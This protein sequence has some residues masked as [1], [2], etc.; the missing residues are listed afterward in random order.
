MEAPEFIKSLRG[1]GLGLSVVF[2]TGIL[3]PLPARDYEISAHAAL[4]SAIID[5]YNA[6]YPDAEIDDAY[7]FDLIRGAKEEDDGNRSLNHFY[8]PV[9][10]RGLSYG[11]KT[12]MRS[13]SWAVADDTNDFTWQKGLNAY[14]QGDSHRAFLILGH[15]LHLLEDVSVPEHVRN[16][17][18]MLDSPYESFT[19]TLVPVKD[20]TPPLV[21]SSLQDYFDAMALYTNT[22][23]YSA[24]TID[25]A[26]Y[27]GPKPDYVAQ[28]GKYLYGFKTDESGSKYHLVRYIRQQNYS[29][30]KKD[31]LSPFLD[32]SDKDILSDYW[33]LLSAK[34]IRYGA[35]MAHTFIAEGEKLKKEQTT[36]K[37]NSKNIYATLAS[38]VDI[39]AST[40]ESVDMANDGLTEA[41]SVSIDSNAIDTLVM[42]I[43]TSAPAVK[44]STT[45][46]GAPKAASAK[47]TAGAAAKKTTVKTAPPKACTYVKTVTPTHGPV[48]INEVAWMGGTASAS[49]EWM[50][51]KNISD[52]PAVISGWQLLSRRGNVSIVI[53]AGATIPAG[54][55]Y[56]LERTDDNSVPNIPADFIY[57]GSLANTDDGLRLVDGNCKPAD[58]VD[59][60]PSWPA[61]DA[62]ARRTME[63]THDFSWHDYTGSGQGSIF[64]TPRAEN[65]APP[66]IKPGSATGGSSSASPS[67]SVAVQP[68][69]AP[70]V[71]LAKQFAKGDVVINE[72]LFD[73]D[74]S[75]AGKEFVELYNATDQNIDLAGWSLQVKSGA[76]GTVK[77]NNFEDG[78]LIVPNGCFL[79]WLGT[80]PADARPQF[81]WSSGTLNNTAATI[82]ISAG[83]E[84]VQ[85]DS[86]TQIV[87]SISYVVDSV[88]GFAAGM[89]AERV[90]ETQ[91]VRARQ[92]PSPNSC[93]RLADDEPV[94]S[95]GKIADAEEKSNAP[96]TVPAITFYKNPNPDGGGSRID[97]AWKT[98]PFVPLINKDEPSWGALAF[99]LNHAPDGNAYLT[100]SERQLTGSAYAIRMQYTIIRAGSF[101]WQNILVLPDT[102]GNM[103]TDNGLFSD[104]YNYDWLVRD[105]AAHATTDTEGKKGDYITVGYYRFSSAGGGSQNLALIYADPK[106][107]YFK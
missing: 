77:K 82:Y 52:S 70:A 9:R 76:A 83:T 100:T 63:R 44:A 88:P 11:G 30:L 90:G 32:K 61:G 45:K 10:N 93:V 48:I 69:P 39:F 16:D 6:A 106:K 53:P 97:V 57:V 74:G 60:S 103:T 42:P 91:T 85:S 86:D 33:R 56:L 95:G 23:F 49:D 41:E 84:V 28:E 35:G 105:S 5:K 64:G 12:W 96:F 89:S 68:A 80:P 27:V 75:D 22:G 46:T 18:H 26:A 25:D 101:P 24:D 67:P 3:Y 47:S 102:R 62:S 38:V 19:K 73:A 2:I 14:A 36:A 81:V 54:G 79:A 31:A 1:W 8:D 107:I 37:K 20:T 15:V 58:D 72:F 94:P 65:S 51:L 71:A 59:G 7:R 55:F 98:Y 40:A 13:K 78:L 17:A 43:K 34:S 99:Y 4:T 66:L 29:W 50:E 87:D 104:A 21:L 92:S